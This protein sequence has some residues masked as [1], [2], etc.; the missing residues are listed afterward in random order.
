[1]I[2]DRSKVK[3][4]GI[5]GEAQSH[6]QGASNQY[7]ALHNVGSSIMGMF[8]G[9]GSGG[10]SNVSAATTPINPNS[11][12]TQDSVG[13]GNTG[14]WVGG[15]QNSQDYGGQVGGGNTGGWQSAQNNQYSFQ[16]SPVAAG[17]NWNDYTAF[18]SGY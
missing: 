7:N 15:M 10:D 2:V 3:A 17:T 8:G 9:G 14:N 18:S 4:G 13:G 11:Y 6:A 5:L 16:G 1:M 12:Y